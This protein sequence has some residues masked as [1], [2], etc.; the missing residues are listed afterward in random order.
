MFPSWRVVSGTIGGVTIGS[1]VTYCLMQ[2]RNGSHSTD[3]VPQT[4]ISKIHFHDYSR[5]KNDNT[6]EQDKNNP[7]SMKHQE[8]MSELKLSPLKFFQYGFPGPV[9]DMEDRYQYVSCYNRQTKNPYW[10]L[11][12][13][14]PQTLLNRNGDRK[15][16]YFREDE[17]IPSDF[18]AKLADYFRSGFDR[19]HQVPAADAKFSQD[20]M[21]ST[22]Y[23]TN[24]SPQVGEGFNRDYWSHFEYFCRGLTKKY[25]DVRIMT[26]P[27]YLPK[28]DETDG[29]FKVTYEMIGNPPNVAV[30]THFFKLIVAE[31]PINDSRDSNIRESNQNKL[32]VAAFVMPNEPISNETKLTDFEVPVNALERSTGLQL[33]HMVRPENITP[34]CKEVKCQLV[35]RTFDNNMKKISSSASNM[36]KDIVKSK[37]PDVEFNNAKTQEKSV[38]VN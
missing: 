11:E 6:H 29:K 17:N 23:L 10:V 18:R 33:L 32:S 38:K 12:H 14:T 35:I 1:T 37:Q 2:R 3:L 7:L 15:G 24:V 19:G 22:F 30:P 16:S 20:A 36:P 26:G 25:N 34:L 27:L 5:G 28:R 4:P 13:I 31:N 9:H 8:M 21:N